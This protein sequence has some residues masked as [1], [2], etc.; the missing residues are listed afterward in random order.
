MSGTPDQPTF[1]PS[2]NECVNPSGHKDYRQDCAT[3]RCHFVITDGRI[4]FCDDCTHD[5]RGQER[6]LEEFADG[7]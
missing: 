6:E 7:T 5:M 4:K 1:H 2:I 3:T